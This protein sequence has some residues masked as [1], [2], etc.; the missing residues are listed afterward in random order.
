MKEKLIN[1]KYDPWAVIAG[2][3]QGIG[4]AFAKLLGEKGINLVLI[5]RGK[6]LLEKLAKELEEKFKVT[7]RTIS[8]DL[9]KENGIQ[10]IIEQTND[11]KVNML[12]YNAAFIPLGPFFKHDLDTHL[13]ILNVNSKGPLMLV[14]HYGRLMK[15]R[16]KGGI[17]LISSMAGVQGTALNVHYGA[18]KAYN[19]GLAEGLWYELKKDNVDVITCVAGNTATPHYYK[20]N[21][22]DPGFFSAKPTDPMDLAK[23]TMKKL[24]RKPS[25]APGSLNKIAVFMMRHLMPRKQA[26]KMVAKS[27]YN[28][29]GNRFD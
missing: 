8:V 6:P 5:A 1:Q 9:G 4:E 28:M 16:K 24:G 18:T 10:A 15:E 7:V 27:T 21:P 26:V 29:F 19:I 13:Q 22:D 25:F 2:G 17:I 11:I 14:E 12:V 23:E 3:S 20:N